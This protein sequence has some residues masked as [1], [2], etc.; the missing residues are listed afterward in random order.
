MTDFRD[1]INGETNMQILPFIKD[2]IT[3]YD[4]LKII[5]QEFVLQKGNDE[6]RRLLRKNQLRQQNRN[7][8]L[9][10]TP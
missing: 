8:N 2:I 1:T 7:V 4:I 10:E 6:V 9:V 5:L 3:Y